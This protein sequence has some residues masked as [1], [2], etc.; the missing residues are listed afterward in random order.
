MIGICEVK[1]SMVPKCFNKPWFTNPCKDAIKECNRA[2]ERLKREP[3][4]GNLNTYSIARAKARRDIQHSKKTSW[5]KYVS[6][7]NSQTQVKSVWNRILKVK[8]KESCIIICV[9]MIEMSSLNLTLLMH[10]Q[11]MF[12]IILPLISAQ[13]PLHLFAR[14]LKS[15]I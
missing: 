6:K 13:M 11:I 9:S 5:R 10:W 15:R 3:T 1:T 8:G 14:K 12:L 4:R 2:L 7:M